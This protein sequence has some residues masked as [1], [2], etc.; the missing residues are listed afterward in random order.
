MANEFE[1]LVL[2]LRHLIQEVIQSQ[3][4]YTA[5]LL[6]DGN[7]N[8]DVPDREGFSYVR[9]D[10]ASNRF[11]EMLNKTVV[12]GDGL[13]I[14]IGRYPWQPDVRQVVSVD[15]ASYLDVGWSDEFGGLGK[16]GTSHQWADGSLKGTDA[17]H[18]YTRQLY[19]LRAEPAGSS[20]PLSV[21]VRPYGQKVQGG[22]KYWPSTSILN[23]TG[24]VP[25]STGTSR[26]ALVYWNPLSGGP[27]GSL[28][29]VTG[30]LAYGAG[31]PARPVAPDG[32]IPSA[33]VYLE[34]GVG[35]LDNT[36]FYDARELLGGGGADSVTVLQVQVFS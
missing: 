13:P 35:A 5:A 25:S 19:A 8:I 28:G 31:V 24:L 34:G 36:M 33:F 26:Y 16:H 10:R 2:F 7:G 20:Y 21:Q 11:V 29:A 23:L 1:E 17:F 6:G 22:Y 14:I 4:S 12:G 30:T 18:V 9:P 3:Y 15:W 32:T 27:Y